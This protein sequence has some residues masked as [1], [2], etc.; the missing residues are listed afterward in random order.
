MTSAL[1]KEGFICLDPTARDARKGA[2]AVTADIEEADVVIANMW[3]ESIGTS[4]GIIQARRMGIPV[5]L[6]DPNYIDS[7]I[8][9]S[10][11]GDF[12]VHDETAAIHKLKKEIVPSLDRDI[13]VKKRGGNTVSFSLKKLQN[14]L[15]AACLQVGI[16]DP[17]FHILL[18]RRVHR[19]ILS[20]LNTDAIP[21]ETIRTRVFQELQKLQS[22]SEFVGEHE[23]LDHA[24]NLQYAW[25]FHERLIKEPA[26]GIAEYVTEIDELI[27][28]IAEKQLE[29]DNL[30]VRL[31]SLTPSSL[32]SPGTG[33]KAQAQSETVTEKI[34]K[35]LGH[36]HALCVSL[37]GKASFAS[38]FQRRG[39]SQAD[40]TRLF[41]EQ[42]LEGK[43]SN[44][45][46]H[47]ANMI[48]SY[49]FVL[50]ASEG[51]RHLDARLRT[52][53][54]LISGAGPN[55]IVRKFVARVQGD[56]IE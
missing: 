16:D 24:K 54:N 45:N 3:R 55:D 29:I 50:Y 53:P 37:L 1:E 7:P 42:L 4:I 14:S 9:Q 33:V 31:N 21:T 36:E 51:L 15:K 32:L 43:Q 12:I 28:Q 26:K 18:S 17:I 41:E 27:G 46:H 10:I 11:V 44:L 35:A 56:K 13:T 49:P 19:A 34:E 52:A 48:K 30:E 47:L 39:V 6:I 23:L 5:I 8:L 20:S 25:E 38:A 2:L 22:D 40:F